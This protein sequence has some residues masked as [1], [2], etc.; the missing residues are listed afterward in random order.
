M[1][2]G[3]SSP[4]TQGVYGLLGLLADP[5]A[6]KGKLDQLTAEKQAALAALTE[7]Q[8]TKDETLKL[9]EAH[10]A[11]HAKHLAELVPLREAHQA[12][13]AAHAEHVRETDA[14]HAVRAKQLDDHEKHLAKKQTILEQYEEAQG[15]RH[16]ARNKVVTEREQSVKTREELLKA[17]EKQAAEALAFAETAK[18]DW[19]RRV[20]L[21]KAAGAV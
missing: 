5:A 18:A 1:G 13:V 16:V 11:E 20:N 10:A 12:K 6:F 7:A 19:E 9:K 3:G 8:H 17:Q 14:A 21:L 4:D 2:G 15:P